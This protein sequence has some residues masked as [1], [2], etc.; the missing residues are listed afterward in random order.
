MSQCVAVCCSVLLKKTHCLQHTATHCNRRTSYGKIQPVSLVYVN[1]CNTLQRTATHCNTLQQADQLWKDTACVV[2]VPEHPR[3]SAGCAQV[4]Q[5]VAVC[6]SV[7]QC[8]AGCCSV[9]Q[10]VAVCCSVLQ[11]AAVCCSAL[12]CVAILFECTHIMFCVCGEFLHKMEPAEFRC[13]CVCVCVAVCY[14]VL[15]HVAVCLEGVLQCVCK[16]C[17]SV[18]Q[19]V[20][21][22][23]SRTNRSLPISGV[24]VCLYGVLQCV[25]VWCSE[26]Q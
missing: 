23:N 4:L 2:C 26:L 17:C 19:C 24:F 25:V 10:C 20:C 11:C 8:A 5:R 14:N 15:H 9:L 7:L 16:M 22:V 3:K 21:V 18:L 6:C 1:H 13:V 12:Q